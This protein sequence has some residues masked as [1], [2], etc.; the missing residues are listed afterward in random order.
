M[1]LVADESVDGPTVEHLRRNGHDVIY[2]AELEPG[3]ED[4][5]VLSFARRK[6]ALLLTADKD[7][8]ELVFRVRERHAGV[9]LLRLSNGDLDENAEL[10]RTCLESHG[11]EMRNS[12][13]VLSHR[14]LRI[15]TLST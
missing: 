8:G 12:F 9:L 10:V 6:Q 11:S 15:R 7:F 4:P 13:S 1:K 5:D 3:I 14:G 2:V